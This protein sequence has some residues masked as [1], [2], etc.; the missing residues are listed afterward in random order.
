MSQVANTPKHLEAAAEQ[1]TLRRDRIQVVD[2]EN[3]MKED[4]KEKQEALEEQ[5][6]PKLKGKKGKEQEKNQSSPEESENPSPK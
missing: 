5:E 2:A 4:G 3:H 6:K 1:L